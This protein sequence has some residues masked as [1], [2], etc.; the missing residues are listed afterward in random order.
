MYKIKNFLLPIGGI[1]VG[2][3]NGLFG[4]GGGMLAVPILRH[5]GLSQKQSHAS[6]IMV[7]LPLSLFSAVLYMKAG[8][9]NISDAYP[10]IPGGI[11][12]ALLGTWCLRKIPD[13][14]LRRVFGLFMIY[15]GIRLFLK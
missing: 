13:L 10:Y 3:I 14:W 15:T 9:L 1:L 2:L 12:G 4:A 11:I 6:A 7:I 5:S 8:R